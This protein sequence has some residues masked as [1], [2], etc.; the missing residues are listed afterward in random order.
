MNEKALLNLCKRMVI[1][2]HNRYIRED[3]KPI[4]DIKDV[5]IL[6]KRNS[7][8]CITEISLKVNSYTDLEYVVVY[9]SKAEDGK[10][11]SSYTIFTL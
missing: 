5:Y 9:D 8:D 2:Y 10:K 3:E 6:E 11:I 1:E 7:S 4:I